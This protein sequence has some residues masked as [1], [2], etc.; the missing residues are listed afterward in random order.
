MTGT[1]NTPSFS[2][3][4]EPLT[5]NGLQIRNRIVLPAMT[6]NYGLNHVPSLQHAAYHQA[7]AAGGVGLI[8]FESIRV[9]LNS[10]GRPQAVNGYDPQCVEPFREIVRRVHQEGAKIFGQVIHLGRQIDGDFEGT[11]SWG[12]SP[13]AWTATAPAPHEMTE[14]DMEE[15][16][17]GHLATVRNLIAAGFDGIELQMAH[18]HLLQQFISPLSNHRTDEY[19][20]SLEGRMR[21][22]LR[23]LQAIRQEVGSDIPLG[24]RLGTEEF[25][26]GGLHID[27][28]ERVALALANAVQVDFFNVSH[29]AY[30]GSYSLGTQIADMS[31]GDREVAMFRQLPARIRKALRSAGFET[32]V[33]AVC[34]FTELAQAE[35]A[36]SQG[37]AD[38]VAMARA[39]LADP[40]LVRKSIEGR[41]DEIRPCIGCNQ[42]CAGFL[43]KDLPVR[44]LV[45]PETGH[46][47]SWEPMKPVPADQ[48][49]R[50]LVVG[51][52]P[53]GMEFAAIAAQRGHQVY[54]WEQSSELGGAL[55]HT[56]KMPRR[57]AFGKLL[58]YQ[59]TALE[60]AG[61]KV[62]LGQTATVESI[63]DFAP[64]RVIL[65]TG[66]R[67]TTPE[68]Q[69]GGRVFNLLDALDDPEALGERVAVV[70]YTGGW[71]ALSLIEHL[72][73]LGKRVHVFTEVLG[74]AWRT[75]IYSTLANRQRLREK[76]V[77]I[78]PLAKVAQW[79][80]A[81]LN[82]IDL[83]DD[84]SFEVNGLDSLVGISDPVTS[85]DFY[86]E[87]RGHGLTVTQVGDCLAPR[88]ALEAIHQGHQLAREV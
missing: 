34:K 30:H 83:S 69:G 46:E 37:I 31:F 78:R 57:T 77:S 49:Q 28:S 1:H 11:I 59:R 68:Y 71:P 3:V 4:L 18:G 67:Q 63:L 88:T 2:K 23:V 36:I 82:L 35:E 44:C 74:F 5:I 26:P 48:A 47:A 6:T 16:I 72:A 17:E 79:D 61:V 55:R 8:I 70:D 60:R 25:V 19:G 21:F 39:H 22:P 52:G 41:L 85:N 66:A 27:E 32:P 33:F 24:V 50:I 87:L 12:A 56:L 73:D 38:A 58:H 86:L 64:D 65:A 45:N 76:R 13:I 7:R 15:V 42:G 54:L 53:A 51:G 80:G 81:T 14:E 10:L 43:E 20:G 84:T 62:S 75:T 9:H 40:A 29:A